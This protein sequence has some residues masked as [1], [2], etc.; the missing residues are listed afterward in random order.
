MATYTMRECGCAFTTEYT[1]EAQPKTSGDDV[2]FYTDR[3]GVF[4]PGTDDPVFTLIRPSLDEIGDSIIAWHA[5]HPQRCR[6]AVS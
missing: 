6:V 1:F 3:M 4:R 5:E 2:V